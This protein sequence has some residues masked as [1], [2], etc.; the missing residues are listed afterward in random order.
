[1][2][3]EKVKTPQGELLYVREEKHLYSKHGTSKKNQYGPVTKKL[4]AN[5]K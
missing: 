4:F 2:K 3:Y 5:A 1:M